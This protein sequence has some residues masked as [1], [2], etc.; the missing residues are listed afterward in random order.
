MYEKAC[1]T[2]SLDRM[3]SVKVFAETFDSQPEIIY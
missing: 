3:I 2:H 1:S